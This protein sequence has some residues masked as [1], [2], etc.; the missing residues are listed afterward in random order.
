MPS[1]VRPLEEEEEEEEK[2]KKITNKYV[3]P[4][5][6]YCKETQRCV[7]FPVVLNCKIRHFNFKNS[8]FKRN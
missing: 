7:L 6:D 2:K 1:N 4:E 3:Y 5:K 8:S